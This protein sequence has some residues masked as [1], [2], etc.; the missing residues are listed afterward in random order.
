M[1][2]NYSMTIDECIKE[3]DRALYKGKEQGRNCVAVSEPES[4][5]TEDGQ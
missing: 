1:F 3:A 2:N 5:K 4:A